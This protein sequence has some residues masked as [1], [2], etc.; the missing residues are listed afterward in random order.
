MHTYHIHIGGLVQGVGFRPL[1]CRLAATFNLTGFVSNTNNGV[2]IECN[3]LPETVKKF[4]QEILNNPPENAVITSHH[5]EEIPVKIFA[6]FGIRQSTHDTAPALML[7]PDIA[8]CDTCRHELLTPGNKRYL[9]PFITCL[10]CGPRYS[11]TTALPYDRPNTTMQPL[12]M[13]SSCNTEYHD[14][15]DRRHYSQ[16]NSC[17]DCAIPMHLYSSSKERVSG[18]AENIL[19]VLDGE[20]K[21]GR[22][23]A[24]KG[25]GGYLLLCDAANENTVQSLRMRKQRP[26]K[27]FALLY[28]DVKMADK[29]VVLHSYEINTL[30]DKAAPIVLCRMKSSSGNGLCK[31]LVAPGLDKIG[32]MLPCSP[33]LVLIA[34]KFGGPLIATSGNIS[35]SPI[36]YT[37]KEALMN[38]FEVADYIL[39]YEREIVAPQ[40]DSV[41]QFTQSGQKLVL[42]RSHGLAPNYFPNPFAASKEVILA[43]GGELKSAF[44]LLNEEHLYVSQFLGDQGS[45]ESQTA[46]KKTVQHFNTLLQ[47]E[48][49]HVLIDKHPGYFVSQLGKTIAAEN[50][51]GVTAIQHHKAHFAAVLAENHLMDAE[52]PVLGFI[53]DGTGYGDDSQIW[54]GEIFIYEEGQI[55]RL[56]Y[57]DYFPQLLGDK[58]S[59]EPRLSALSIL[60]NFPAQ[61]QLLQK[62]FSSQEWKYYQQ[63][64]QQPDTLLT[65]SMGR[66]LDG[67]ASL[68]GVCQQNTYEGEAVMKLEALAASCQEV[69]TDYYPVELRSNRISWYP[70]IQALLLDIE[71]EKDKATMAW[72]VF[73]SLYK[74]ILQVA[75]HFNIDCLAFSGGVFQ[76]ALLVHLLT[77]NTPANKTLFFHRQLSANDENIGLGQ[78]AYYIMNN[79]HAGKDIVEKNRISTKQFQLTH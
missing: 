44:C 42:R 22:I 64:I 30:H 20:L 40:D 2:H 17:T 23:I 48:P 46:F 1:V 33:L 60:K 73:Y 6:S 9:Y 28:A 26:A 15:N 66:F 4:Y 38:L 41:L 57:M 74:M 58:M 27:P 47:V 78:V 56:A 3:A 65:S 67:I 51:I 16:T 21:K 77:E 55:E 12:S 53:F 36:I 54:G 34:E 29:D 45:L 76:N 59:K 50:N 13:C 5:L 11:I 72:K 70:F 14:I 69:S 32:L 25:I 35:G 8:V 63:L 43:M 24:V 31:E 39:T 52:E 75:E 79:K 19:Q 68:L 10:N 18:D 61:Q 7:T 71:V 49:R 62:H 37:D